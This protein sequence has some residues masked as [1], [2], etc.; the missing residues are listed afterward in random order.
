MQSSLKIKIMVLIAVIINVY[1]FAGID[2]NMAID[3]VLNQVLVNEL[4]SITVHI[5]NNP[6]PAQDGF[7]THKNREIDSLYVNSWIFFVDDYPCAKW[8]HPCRYLVMDTQTGEYKMIDE[9][10]YPSNEYTD[11]ELIS[12]PIEPPLYSSQIDPPTNNPTNRPENSHLY[13]VIIGGDELGPEMGWDD[14]ECFW[15]DVSG[16]YCT[17]LKYGYT[18]ENIIVHYAEGTG[19]EGIEDLDEPFED[20]SD[21][22]DYW[23]DKDTIITTFEYL[24]QQLTPND[25]LFVYLNDHGNQVNNQNTISYLYLPGENI[26]QNR[27]YDYDLS[28]YVR[29]INCSQMIFLI[30]SCYSGGFIDD[31]NDPLAICQNRVIHTNSDYYELSHNENWMT[32]FGWGLYPKY[33]E[34]TLYWTAAA[35]DYYPYINNIDPPNTIIRAWEESEI[36]GDFPFTDYSE[37]EFGGNN[38][39]NHDDFPDYFV[40]WDDGNADYLLQMNEIFRYANNWDTYSNDRHIIYN[41]LEGYYNVFGDDFRFEEH[42]QQFPEEP[43]FLTSFLTLSGIAG[44]LE[45][46]DSI[47]GD[48]LFSGEFIVQEGVTFSILAGSHITLSAEAKIIVEEGATLI[49]END[50]IFTGNNISNQI[51]INGSLQIGNNVHFTA[52]EE[53]YWVGLYLNETDLVTIENA[54][55]ENCNLTS[56]DTELE[57]T[58]S[59][60]TNSVISQTETYLTFT[61]N[62]L[63]DSYINAKRENPLHYDEKVDIRNCTFNNEIDNPAIYIQSYQNYKIKDCNFNTDGTAI[64]IYESGFGSIHKIKNN[65]ITNYTTGGYNGNGIELYNSFADI[66][67]H[68]DISH[69]ET[70]ISGYNTCNIDIYGDTASP[71]QEIHHNEYDEMQYSHDSFPVYMKMCVVG[72]DNWNGYYVNC[73]DHIPRI[74]HE[75]YYNDFEPTYAQPF[76]PENVFYPQEEYVYLPMW[77][78]GRDGE[79]TQA[80]EMFELAREYIDNEEFYLA[81]QKLKE[82][83]A[84]YPESSY[85]LGSMKELFMVE[86]Y[87]DHDYQNLKSFYDNDPNMSNNEDM[88]SLADFYSNYCSIRLAEY[89]QAI[90]HFEEIIDDPA[91]VSDSVFAVIDAGYTYLLMEADTT[92]DHSFVGRKPWLKPVSEEAFQQTR[93]ELLN[94]LF[95]KPDNESNESIPDNIMLYSN[96]PNPFNPQ[97]TI[98]FALPEESKVELTIYNIKGQKVRSLVSEEMNRG[99]HRKLWNGK[100]SYDKEVSSGVYFYKL[101][102]NGKTNAIKKC[103]LVK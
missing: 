50:C 28:E 32:A 86:Y 90:Y 75:I 62:T 15:N 72:D 30:D 54:T 45:N 38:G 81:K 65:T 8:C 3:I 89:P 13:A 93:T 14:D 41:G 19:P 76:M 10:F 33:T 5:K 103:L 9:I 2:R 100:D 59:Q 4:D 79:Q 77:D 1:L 12:S 31:L 84:L 88:A 56:N 82:V 27:L 102:V 7:R 99:I 43:N 64:D 83:I 97:T 98:S 26:D 70:G 46:T 49:I 101:N 94:D 85:A 57:V 42:P 87:T 23:A 6:V 20:P 44:S 51:V 29:N 74:P 21:D 18:K 48:Y 63:E 34:F 35:R 66:K 71:F 37:W 24:E 60:F 47:I 73:V 61:D 95:G 52:E 53:N 39:P 36:T 17:L 55:F 22:I 25:M 68:N 40:D 92:R 78:S 96:F 91:S 69:K 58:N 11:F 67:G 16:V 80:E